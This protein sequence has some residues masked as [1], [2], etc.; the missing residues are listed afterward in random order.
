MAG[1][2]ARE[3]QAA[4]ELRSERIVVLDFG[5]QYRQLIA[6]RVREAHVYC[7]V[8]P[9][10]TPAGEILARRPKGIIFS[11]GPASVYEPDAP[12]PDP[13]L[14]RSGVPI[15]GICYGMQV[16]VHQLGGKVE[17]AGHREYGRRELQVLDGRDLFAGLSD[18]T[19]LEVWMSHGDHVVEPPEG[20]EVIAAT[21]AAPVA[22]VR[23]RELPLYGVQFHPE[24][25]HTPEGGAILRNF[26]YRVC[27]ARGLWRMSAFLEHQVSAL[28]E[29]IGQDR[30]VLGLSGGVDS[31]VTAALLDR[32]V[33]DR[34]TCIFVDHGLLRE[35][36]ADE[37]R[38]AFAFLGRRLVVVDARDRFLARLAGVV[39]PEEKRRRIGAEF[40]RVFEEE[41]RKLG[42]VRF[43][44]QG[45]LYPDVIE[46]GEPGKAGP[47]GRAASVIKSHHNVG[48]LPP[49][50]KMELVEP[51]RE[52]FKDEV[53]E[54]ARELGLPQRLIGRHPFPGPGLAVRILGPVDAPSL[55]IARR[56]DTIVREELERAGL[57]DQV[58][59]AFAVLTPLRTVGVMGDGRTYGYVVAVRAVTSVDGMTA[60]WARLPH[61]VLE[62]I[63]SRITGEINQ[64]NRVVY[65]ITSKPPGTIEWE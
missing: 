21:P 27:G 30:V 16:M 45:T 22:A 7:E 18:G 63:A 12:R 39:D 26:L 48:G 36:E 15:L 54:L 24:V 8:L 25:S 4:A 9:A 49:D 46:S 43:L 33:G 53:R 32:A 19:P 23:H 64:V 62:R 50:M 61:Q 1:S 42:P 57:Y 31:S 65:D 47:G 35:G 11:G 37:V 17:P 52:L 14:Y 10:T 5:A 41:A 51:L 34:L 55:A 60:D 58:W 29:R 3:P 2:G 40:V 6:R 44:A 38:E 59:Q 28:R 56:A 13:E 20:F